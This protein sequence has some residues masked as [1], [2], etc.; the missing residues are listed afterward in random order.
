MFL[1]VTPT[2]RRSWQI[3]YRFD[4]QV[5]T[6]PVGRYPGISQAEAMFRTEQLRAQLD[7][8]EDP[9]AGSKRA[10]REAAQV[11]RSRRFD[12]VARE[13]FDRTV[14]SRRE[15]RY[16]ARVWSRVEA[17]LLP[18]L[19]AK[20]IAA[21]E[22]SDVLAALQA[23]ERRPRKSGRGA[24][25]GK[26][27]IYSARV[28]GRYA[29]SIFRYA[30]ISHGLRFNPAEGI[31]DVLLPTPK[32]VGQPS[33]APAQVPLFMAALQRPHEDEEITR[34]GLH[35][36]MNVVLR[37]V[38]LRGGRWSEV[39]GDE[40]RVPAERMKMRRP[41]VVP[42]SRQAQAILARLRELTGK[43]PLILPGRRPGHPISENTLIFC[44]YALGFKFDPE[45]PEK[46]AASVHGWRA[47]FSTWAHATGRWPSEWIEACLA[48]AD[49]NVVRASY[50]RQDWLPQRREI[51]QAWSDW[52]DVQADVAEL[53]H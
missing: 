48:H 29:S 22:P 46:P 26:P 24:K 21:I 45:R 2:G 1:L 33:L 32:T 3:T 52:L 11:A 40:W 36:V 7:R 18:S 38:E 49:S 28:V 39:V 17:N 42:L 5:R 41:H 43:G 34:L 19:G 31:G 37:S 23:M 10:Q 50:N 9:G 16:A 27:P 4:G 8:G 12:T 6:L 51:M 13:W 53:V 47:T 15:E 14:A 44:T 25:E 20:D 35:L 30:R